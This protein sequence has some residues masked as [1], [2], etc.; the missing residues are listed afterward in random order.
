MEYEATYICSNS[1]RGFEFYVVAK[2]DQ[3]S[4]GLCWALCDVERIV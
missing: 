3:I 4:C 2:E 1:V